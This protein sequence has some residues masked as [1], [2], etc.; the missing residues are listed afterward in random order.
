MTLTRNSALDTRLI[1]SPHIESVSDM[2]VGSSLD[3]VF[4]NAPPPLGCQSGNPNACAASGLKQPAAVVVGATIAPTQPGQ[5]SAIP[6]GSP[7]PISWAPSPNP[8]PLVFPPLCLSPSI[9]AQEP[10]SIDILIVPLGGTA[11]VPPGVPKQPNQLAP[12]GNPLGNP[13][14]GV[15]PNGLFITEQNSYFVGPSAPV[16]DPS[17]CLPHMVRQQVGHFLYIADRLRGEI[18]VFNSNRMTVV[19]RLKVVDP[20]NMAMSPNLDLLAVTNRVSNQV[21]FIDILPTS[22]TF[23]TV[24]QVTTLTGLQPTA[25]VWQPDNEDILVCN[26][27]DNSVSIISAFSQEER[28]RV[29]GLPGKPIDICVG[30]RHRPPAPQLGLGRDTYFGYILSETGLVTIFESGPDGVGGWGPDSLIGSGTQVFQQPKRIVLDR[31]FLSGALWIAHSDPFNIASQ[32]PSGQG[33]GAISQL[34]VTSAVAGVIPVTAGANLTSRQLDL[35]VFVSLGEGTLSGSPV[36]IAFDNMLNIAGG[37]PNPTTA[38]SAPGNPAPINGKNW[39]RLVNGA[40]VPSST[41]TFMFISV[42]NKSSIDVIRLQGG[43]QRLDVDVTTPGTQSIFAD[44]ATLLCDY[45]RQ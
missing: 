42:P 9:D 15:P 27:G 44:G 17:A 4:N 25:I 37:T 36:D 5:F 11:G 16:P 1:R 6:P 34:R 35:D 2:M 29:G 24:L 32:T 20:T 26:Q 22:S 3:V 7:N 18:V 23:N 41:P 28:K 10:T 21:T 14:L 39:A 40:W 19:D 31:S 45:W 12:N 8:P 38:F 33:G 30:P 13:G 43:F